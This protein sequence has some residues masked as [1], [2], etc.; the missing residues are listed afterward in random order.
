MTRKLSGIMAEYRAM[1]E[2]LITCQCHLCKFNNLVN[3][4]EAHSQLIDMLV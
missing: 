2:Y 1:P 4:R 3:Y